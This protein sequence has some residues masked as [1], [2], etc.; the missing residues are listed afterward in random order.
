MRTIVVLLL[1]ISA[2]SC[3]RVRPHEREALARRAMNPAGDPAEQKLDGHVEEYREGSIGGA[4]AGGGG[5]G[6]N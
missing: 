1:A 6:C 4:G 2:A 5:C 3:V